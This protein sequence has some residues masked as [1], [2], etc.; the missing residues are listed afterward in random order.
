VILQY[1][2]TLV[3]AHPEVATL[4][5]YLA[6]LGAHVGVGM[7][8]H[9]VRLG[10]F[11]WGKVGQWIEADVWTARGGAILVTF[12]LTLVTTT[13]PGADWRAAFTPAFLALVAAAGASILPI[14]RDTLY[15]LMQL[16]SGVDPKP[17]ARLQPAKAPAT[18]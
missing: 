16:I 12:L 8:L 7:L 13:V 2:V 1:L 3:H 5:A 14:A 15:E 10:D 11:D 4:F 17:A 18:G 9:A 6:V